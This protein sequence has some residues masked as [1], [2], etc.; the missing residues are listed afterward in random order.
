MDKSFFQT[1]TKQITLKCF[2]NIFLF[3]NLLKESKMHKFAFKFAKLLILLFY[4]LYKNK[5]LISLGISS[6]NYL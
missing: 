2:K 1:Q 5:L 3:E 6:K 4:I